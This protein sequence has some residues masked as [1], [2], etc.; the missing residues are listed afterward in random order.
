M[1]CQ[2]LEASAREMTELESDCI[3]VPST[4]GQRGELPRRYK[5]LSG[6]I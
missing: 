4:A 3:Q 6:D 1:I 2:T 5:N